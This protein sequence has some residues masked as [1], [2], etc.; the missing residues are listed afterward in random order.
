MVTAG[1]GRRVLPLLSGQLRGFALHLPVT[2]IEAR[3]GGIA[4]WGFPK[5]IA[6]MDFTEDPGL[7]RVELSEGGSTILTLTV[8]PRGP[9]VADR[10]PPA[11][12]TTRHGEL[13]QT[14]HR[15]AR[16]RGRTARTVAQDPQLPGPHPCR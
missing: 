7:R 16:A 15:G 11:A 13:L 12:N 10:R 5:F 8:R 2:T 9:V 6:D 3:D 14:V 1:P 4:G